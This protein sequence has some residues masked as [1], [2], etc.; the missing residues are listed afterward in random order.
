M[1]ILRAIGATLDGDTE[2]S[3]AALKA[4]LPP[5]AELLRIANFEDAFRTH[6]YGQ[7][8]PSLLCATLRGERLGEWDDA[9]SVATRVL[10]LEAL[11]PLARNG[12]LRLR[13]KAHMAR[14][15]REEACADATAA[16]DDAAKAQY[17]WLEM[18]AVRD[19]LAALDAGAE[20][21]REAAWA[22]MRV[23]TERL[24]AT[25]EELASVLGGDVAKVLVG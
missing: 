21:A 9:A 6:A 14:G 24:R 7:M 3:K 25:A 23:V 5:T 19:L 13:Y 2:E 18:L 12:A 22:R 8:H 4:W 16:A 10:E 1:L 20:E 11:N 15:M 17:W